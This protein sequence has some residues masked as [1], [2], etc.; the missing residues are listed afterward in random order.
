MKGQ[1][2]LH[3][4]ISFQSKNHCLMKSTARHGITLA[5]VLVALGRQRSHKFKS[6]QGH[7][8]KPFFNIKKKRVGMGLGPVPSTHMM[9]RN[10][11][12]SSCRGSDNLFLLPQAHS[13]YT[14]THTINI[15][16]FFKLRCL[17]LYHMPLIL[18]QGRWI[19]SQCGLWLQQWPL[20]EG[21]NPQ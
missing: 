6:R 7:I 15:H 20:P 10:S 11:C 13:W 21:T 19:H 8:M 2:E 12:N 14:H 1:P 3:S 17:A 4:K 5:S 9:V 16:I 18:V